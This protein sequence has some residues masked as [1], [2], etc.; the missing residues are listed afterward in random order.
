MTEKSHSASGASDLTFIMN[1]AGQSLRERFAILLGEDTRYFD[2]LVG[3]FFI[4]GFYRLYR[5]YDLLPANA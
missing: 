3:Y 1:E 5:L 4:S 2:C